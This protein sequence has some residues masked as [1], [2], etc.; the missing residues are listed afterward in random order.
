MKCYG[1]HLGGV[2]F[3][4]LYSELRDFGGSTLMEPRS[5]VREG[6]GGSLSTSTLL[7]RV[8]FVTCVGNPSILC[9]DVSIF[10]DSTKECKNGFV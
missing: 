9:Q 10:G 1:L 5:I 3:E 7:E 6:R 2:S 8:V 4:N